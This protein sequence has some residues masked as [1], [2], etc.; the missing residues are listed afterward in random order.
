MVAGTAERRGAE[1]GLDAL[2]V[3]RPALRFLLGLMS[4]AV[5]S[6][7][8]QVLE[9]KLL[10]TVSGLV[11][12]FCFLGAPALW[13]LRTK[14]DDVL[15]GQDLGAD[16]YEATRERAT[17]LRR[18]LMLRAAWVALC[19][20][21]AFLPLL[22]S[23]LLHAVW[24]WMILLGAVGLSE[25]VYAFLVAHQWDEDL[26]TYRDQQRVAKIRKDE[27]E[28]AVSR[29]RTSQQ[30]SSAVTIDWEAPEVSPCPPRSTLI[31]VPDDQNNR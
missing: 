13:S 24:E 30:A 2:V 21:A 28:R 14:V 4:V 29:I 15:S 7:L 10:A 1:R 8:W 9:M 16:A 12:P 18:R 20:L 6:W 23:Q 22:A 3:P 31:E 5:A 11:G 17:E 26:R 19:S 25:A 27:R